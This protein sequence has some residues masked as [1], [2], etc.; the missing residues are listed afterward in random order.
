M[1]ILVVKRR[2]AVEWVLSDLGVTCTEIFHTKFLVDFN[3]IE[4]QFVYLTVSV[5]FS[6]IHVSQIKD[7]NKI[8]EII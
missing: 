4:E 7:T 2:E 8:M 6:F 1:I 5:F 3:L